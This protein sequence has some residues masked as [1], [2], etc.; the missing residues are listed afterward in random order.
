MRI[1]HN[2][3]RARRSGDFGGWLNYPADQV[4]LRR[5]SGVAQVPEPE[6]EL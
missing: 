2:R 5:A 4:P 6:A 1:G 3:G